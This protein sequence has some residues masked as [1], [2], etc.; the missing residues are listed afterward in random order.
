MFASS[1]PDD[2]DRWGGSL[3][4]ATLFGYAGLLIG[5]AETLGTSMEG[6]IGA[7]VQAVGEPDFYA[8]GSETLIR[9]VPVSQQTE[10]R[11]AARQLRAKD[12]I[13][14]LNAINTQIHQIMFQVERA[15]SRLATSG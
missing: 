10:S 4:T 8:Q 7:S 15:V 3:Q 2:E 1:S 11:A 14:E 13:S 5:D 6:T 12:L 9:G